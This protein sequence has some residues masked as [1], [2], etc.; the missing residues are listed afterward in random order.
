M[1]RTSQ[2]GHGVVGRH[3]LWFDTSL[4]SPT[5]MN[6]GFSRGQWSTANAEISSSA[7]TA[8]K[9]RVIAAAR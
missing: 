8:N 3:G 9:A 4:H 6:V 2:F 1:N 7:A 5:G